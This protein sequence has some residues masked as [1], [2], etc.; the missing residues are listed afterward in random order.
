MFT[1]NPFYLTAMPTAN[2]PLYAGEFGLDYLGKKTSTFYSV[3]IPSNVDVG[4]WCGV[5]DAYGRIVYEGI[6]QAVDDNRIETAPLLSFFDNDCIAGQNGGATYT[7]EK[8]KKF[9]EFYFIINAYH[10][11]QIGNAMTITASSS[12]QTA[13]LYVS[14]RDSQILNYYTIMKEQTDAFGIYPYMFMPYESGQNVTMDIRVSNK[15]KLTIGNNV[16]VIHNITIT[17]GDTPYNTLILRL[18]LGGGSSSTFGT[19]LYTDG[20]YE[21][22]GP[23]MDLSK[24]FHNIRIKTVIMDNSDYYPDIRFQLLPPLIYN[25]DI[26]FDMVLENNFYDFYDMEL[27]QKMELFIDGKYYETI[28]TAWSMKFEND[29]ASIV[30][31]TCGTARS[32]LTEVLNAEK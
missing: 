32:K 10:T 28:L 26:S 3:D 9:I 18:E 31:L 29:L 23:Q 4:D 20:T 27:G 16:N 25:H 11:R 19:V 17:E 8:I 15:P 13:D 22:T 5:Y 1:K 2:F 14:S 7:E 21:G 24:C 12:T 30:H 6:I